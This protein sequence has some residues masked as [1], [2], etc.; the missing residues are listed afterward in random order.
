MRNIIHR[1]RAELRR[2]FDS[3][4]QPHDVFFAVNRPPLQ[5]LTSFYGLPA[6]AHRHFLLA[7]SAAP[8]SNPP[9]TS[10][11]PRAQPLSKRNRSL[12]CKQNRASSFRS[13][14]QCDC[15]APAHHRLCTI[16]SASFIEKSTDILRITSRTSSI[17]LIAEKLNFS[18]LRQDFNNHNF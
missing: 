13:K 8:R 9:E 6:R 10:S 5:S 18:L 11:N 7:A 17:E 12:L 14:I 2:S 16:G 1:S 3:N 15:S 4:L